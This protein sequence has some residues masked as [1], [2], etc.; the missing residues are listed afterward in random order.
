MEQVRLP[1]ITRAGVPNLCFVSSAWGRDPRRTTSSTSYQVQ[2]C[3]RSYSS[4]KNSKHIECASWVI[5]ELLSS[6]PIFWRV[7]SFFFKEECICR[8]K[9]MPH[10]Q[11]TVRG[12][13][14]P[15]LA[16]TAQYLPLETAQPRKYHYRPMEKLRY[17]RSTDSLIASLLAMVSSRTECTQISYLPNPLWKT[18]SFEIHFL[19]HNLPLYLAFLDPWRVVSTR[20]IRARKKQNSDWIGVTS[21]LYTTFELL[22]C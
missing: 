6:D 3:H 14:M 4:R 19:R 17:G 18:W 1:F 20:D 12:H 21:T 15:Q 16:T 7:A 13:C 9:M 11:I 2:I 10:P 22:S 5:V 8:A